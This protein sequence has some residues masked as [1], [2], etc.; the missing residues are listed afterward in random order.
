MLR[1]YDIDTIPSLLLF[2]E[3]AKLVSSVVKP[4]VHRMQLKTGSEKTAPY[5]I[6]RQEWY[7]GGT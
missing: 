4:G 2:R 5:R 7:K 6:V 1:K 3:R